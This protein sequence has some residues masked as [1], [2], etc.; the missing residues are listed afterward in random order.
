MEQ[1]TG[2]SMLDEF[3]TNPRLQVGLLLIVTVLVVYAGL[4]WHDE[5]TSLEQRLREIK[6]EL[7]VVQQQ[8]ANPKP[9]QEYVAQVD[10][11]AQ[12]LYER[13]WF[14]DTEAAAQ[15]R[16]NDWLTGIAK[17]AKLIRPVIALA[18]VT[19]MQQSE[20]AGNPSS[21]ILKTPN[22]VTAAA[23]GELPDAAQLYLV[24]SSL[25]FAF[26]P[27]TLEAVLMAIEGSPPL[28]VIE[29]IT[30]NKRTL[31]VEVRVKVLA[32]LKTP[33][34]STTS[35]IGSQNVQP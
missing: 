17:S 4:L 8:N 9:W 3:R 23:P 28:A 31:A 20:F 1:G 35:L 18:T 30:V 10:Q 14:V 26:T 27:E 24:K 11:R 5:V 25:N 21:A 2:N 15:A 7:Q 33:I 6:D 22:T 13:L 32:T 34:A 16:L 12:T 19:P 29:S